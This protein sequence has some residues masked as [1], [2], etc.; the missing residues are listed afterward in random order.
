VVEDGAARAGAAESEAFGP[1][2][3]ALSTTWLG[4]TMG[5]LFWLPPPPKKPQAASVKG[6]AKAVAVTAT[7]LDLRMKTVRGPDDGGAEPGI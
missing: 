4:I 5:A 3:E 6:V 1:L 2:G 7:N